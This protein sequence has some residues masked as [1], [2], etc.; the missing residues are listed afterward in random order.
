MHEVIIIGAGSVGTPTAMSLAERGI[1]TLVIDSGRS[2]GQGNNKCAIGG[3]R[4]THS[5]PAKVALSLHSI[6][7]FSTWEEI[8]REDIGWYMGGYTFIAYTEAISESLQNMIPAQQKAGLNIKW[9]NSDEILR[10]VPGIKAEGL[11]GGTFSP[12]DGSASPME[13]CY[14]FKRN[15][16]RCGAEFRFGETVTSIEK[17]GFFKVV[18]DRAEYT[19]ANVINCAGSFGR[20]V[21]AMVGVDLPVYPDMHEAGITEPVQRFFNPMVVDISRTAGSANY[22][23]YQYSTGQVV[24][25]ITPDPPIPGKGTEETSTFLPQVASRMVNLYPRLANIKVR[26]TWRGSYPQTP[27]GT[28][29][30]GQVG[31]E[32]FF[33]AVGMCGQGFMLGPGVGEVMARLVAGQSTEEDRMVLSAMRLDREFS[34]REALK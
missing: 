8:H 7:T 22:Y 34:G 15:A 17:S 13:S 28:P 5:D 32:G 29:I 24:F 26:R 11:F 33:A 25:C 14:A 10:L 2:A 20:E 3:I 18:T 16:E 27:D 21:G 30:I 9:C 1:T 23:F 31:P 4:A 6:K 19:A 12:E